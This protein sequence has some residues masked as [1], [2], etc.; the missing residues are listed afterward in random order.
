MGL[1]VLVLLILAWLRY[2]KKRAARLRGIQPQAPARLAHL[3]ALEEL[4]RIKGLGLI[5]KGEIKTF[6]ILVS[7]S[8]R[9]YIKARY[10]VDAPEMTTWE[11]IDELKYLGRVGQSA[12]RL[13]AEFLEACDLVKFAKYRPKIVEINATF[14]QA[15]EIV[16]KTR[17][18]P[19]EAPGYSSPDSPEPA[20]VAAGAEPSGEPASGEKVN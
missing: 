11:L 18:S 8:I 4:D 6:H 3:V 19:D 15:Y 5:E 17:P 9:N 14:N 20:A 1:A 7:D 13:I 16:E 2:L 12:S 10:G